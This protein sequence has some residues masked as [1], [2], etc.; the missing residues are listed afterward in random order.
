MKS[1]LNVQFKYRINFFNQSLTYSIAC[2]TLTNASLFFSIQVDM[3]IDATNW[4]C[5][6]IFKSFCI[7]NQME[8]GYSPMFEVATINS[9]SRRIEKYTDFSSKQYHTRLKEII[10]SNLTNIRFELNFNST[11]VQLLQNLTFYSL[12]MFYCPK[13]VFSSAWWKYILRLV[14]RNC[15][16]SAMENMRSTIFGIKYI[17]S[18]FLLLLLLLFHFIFN[19]N[20]T[21]IHILNFQFYYLLNR[22]LL[23][24]DLHCAG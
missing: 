13:F 11:S 12:N 14:F 1:E 8:F 16:T 7:T 18:A 23:F 20:L 2:I 3:G 5:T 21:K 22:F 17:S 10:H 9:V 6:K 4:S 19:Y 24:N 15:V